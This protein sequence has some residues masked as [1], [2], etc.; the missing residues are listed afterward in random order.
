MVAPIGA[1]ALRY[2]RAVLDDAD[3]VPAFDL[4]DPEQV[5]RNYLENFRHLGVQPVSRD[6]AM[7]LMAEWAD[8]IAGRQSVP[9]ITH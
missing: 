3:D 1:L 7:D 5:W 8:A 4:P 6:R 9:S 2:H